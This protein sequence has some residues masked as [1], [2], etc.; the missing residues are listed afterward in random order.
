MGPKNMP[1]DIVEKINKAVK[2]AINDSSIK[3]TL[4]AQGLQ[5]SGPSTPAEFS[6]FLKQELEKYQKIVKELNIKS[7]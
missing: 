7:E 3:A 1:S 2:Q 4:D 6:L 5:T